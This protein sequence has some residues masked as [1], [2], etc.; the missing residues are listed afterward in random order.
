MNSRSLKQYR[1][2]I[3]MQMQKHW[4]MGFLGVIGFFQIPAAT[5]YFSGDGPWYNLLGLLWFLWFLELIPESE[6]EN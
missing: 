4:Y 1:K 5:A 6:G 3:E 2:V